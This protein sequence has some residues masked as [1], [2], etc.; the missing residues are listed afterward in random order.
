MKEKAVLI[1][2]TIKNLSVDGYGLIL[3]FEDDSAFA[4]NASDGGMSSYDYYTK[5]EWEKE[6]IE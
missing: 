1:G 3:I 6:C 5:S 4:Y 2:K